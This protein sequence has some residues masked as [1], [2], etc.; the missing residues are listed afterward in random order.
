MKNEKPINNSKKDFKVLVPV[1]A[2]LC[3]IPFIVLTKDYQTEFTK[4]DWFNNKEIDQIDSFE[5][6]KSRFVMIMG[7]I[8][9]VVIA[10]NEYS[11]MKKKKQLFENCDIKVMALCAVFCVMVIISS[12]FSKYSHL[13]F[14]GGGYGQWQTMWV[15]LSFVVLFI[16]AYMFVD[17]EKR[18]L[19]TAKCLMVST[20]LVAVIGVLQTVGHNPLSW[21]WVQKIMTSRSEVNG[22]TFSDGVSNV[23]LTFSN[24]NYVG[25]YVALIFPFVIAFAATRVSENKNKR[26]ACCVGAV[27]VAAGLLCTLFGSSSSAGA[28]SVAAGVI[29]GAVILLSGIVFKDKPKGRPG[30][31]EGAD[32]PD[33]NRAK[34][35]IIPVAA[36][37]VIV[38]V[39][40]GVSR[41]SFFEN[42]VNKLL[43]GGNDTRNVASIVNTDTGLDVEMRSGEE[44]E[45]IPS[46]TDNGAIAFGARDAK[47]KEI[48]FNK[49]EDNKYYY[50]D[51][52]RFRMLT[53]EVA[54][55]QVGESQYRGFRFNDAPNQISW[56]FM[57]VDN[58]WQ[59][60]SPF[61]KLLKLREVE[62]FGFENYQNIANRRGYIW[63]RT[64][65]LLKTYWFSGIG[66][67]AFIIAFPN[68]DFVGSKRVGG[69]TTLVDKPHNAFLQ[70][71]IQTGGISALAYCGLWILYMVQG[72]KLFWRRRKYTDTEKIGLGLLVGIF[73]FAVAGITND[74][75]VGSQTIYWIL[76]G[77]GYA[78]NRVIAV[79]RAAVTENEKK[80]KN[81]KEKAAQSR[82]KKGRKG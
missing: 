71:Y 6:A 64:I 38:A 55:F 19:L 60:F 39:G 76:L 24:P 17:S 13:A 31:A 48:I 9:A 20:A 67:N 1:L 58:E 61:G 52:D 36:V 28:I 75:V 22:V 65:P 59:Y 26:I 62:H 80:E 7:A 33:R 41:T 53:I 56:S 4:F 2:A 27:V 16:Y 40:V 79:S 77:A 11:K 51:D 57:Y 35:Y 78:V 69:S 43:Q 14:T 49:S 70:V 30:Q 37:L 42:T 15:L 68:D 21:G 8:A 66:P 18:I 45:L 44:F 34:R 63:S 72:V 46:F 23:I 54:N 29:A 10:L 82:H 74:T 81:G 50:M 3:L 32:K 5:Y 47:G 12:L 25:P 73:S